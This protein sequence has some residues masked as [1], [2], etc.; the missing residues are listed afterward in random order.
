[1]D[2]RP[3]YS[4]A[5]QI[6]AASTSAPTPTPTP[7]EAR[8]VWVTRFDWTTAGRPADP[9]RLRELVDRCADAG[10]NMLLFQVRAMADAYYLSGF[11]PWAERVSGAGL[12]Q[13]PRPF[14]DPLNYLI[15]Q[16]HAAGLQV[17]AHFNVYPAAEGRPNCTSTPPTPLRP[18]PLFWQLAARYGQRDGVNLGLQQ[19]ENG[20]VVCASYRYAS[21]ASPWVQQHLLW[22]AAELATHYALDGLHL[23]HVR[24]GARQASADPVSLRR[25]HGLDE[26][27]ALPP[28]HLDDA[29]A[30]WQRQQ[31]NQL[32]QRF[33]TLLRAQPRPLWLSAAV[34]PI[35]RI[36]P[37]LALPQNPSSGYRDYYQDSQA[38]AQGGYID[39]LMPMIYPSAYNC[40]DDSYWTFD[41]WQRLAA[42]FQAGS[43]GRLIIPGIGG[44]YCTF[45]EIARRID[46]ARDL[47]V[48]GQALFSYRS[49]FEKDYLTELRYGPYRSYAV[50]PTLPWRHAPGP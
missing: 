48:A 40:P 35:Y 9:A 30:A 45:A 37:A 11:A 39:A 42:D 31:I 36:T 25:Y 10:F 2:S 29:Y 12:G 23:D 24:Y 1:M 50:P 27:A 22:A 7:Q 44:G 18:T 16:A 4:I 19:A 5:P 47:G 13:P 41:I 43:G 15:E 38:W 6:G 33:Y 8:A 32:V 28:F 34:W 46:K 26:D 49:L 21:P 14:W 20:E 17:H 3:R